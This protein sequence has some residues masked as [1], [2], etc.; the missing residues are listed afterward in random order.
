MKKIDKIRAR[1]AARVLLIAANDCIRDAESKLMEIRENIEVETHIDSALAGVGVAIET[2][3][4]NQ[5]GEK[6]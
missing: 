2:I 4:K 1:E 5:S 6:I 3:V